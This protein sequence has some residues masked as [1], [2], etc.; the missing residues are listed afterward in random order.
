MRACRWNPE[1]EI[2]NDADPRKVFCSKR[3]RNAA[4]EARVRAAYRALREG[5]F[6]RPTTP[7]P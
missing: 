1:H 5:A 3:C 2:A 4:H 7:V 6:T